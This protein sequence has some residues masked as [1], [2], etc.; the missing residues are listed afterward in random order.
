MKIRLYQ[1]YDQIKQCLYDV[2]LHSKNWKV[3]AG[4]NEGIGLGAEI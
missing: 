1:E 3:G 4:V 2:Y